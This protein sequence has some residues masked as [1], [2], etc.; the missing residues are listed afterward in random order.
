MLL[1]K[2]F[3]CSEEI[4]KL[5]EQRIELIKAIIDECDHPEEEVMEKAYSPETAV[6]YS[7]PPIKVCRLCGQAEEG[8]G[9]GYKIFNNDEAPTISEKKYWEYVRVLKEQN[10]NEIIYER[11]VSK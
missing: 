3:E 1:E 4:D 9:V 7:R 10:G 8:W 11:V 5:K 2:I 6:C